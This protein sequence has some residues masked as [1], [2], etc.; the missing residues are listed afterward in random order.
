[1]IWEM[2]ARSC[3]LCLSF[4][5]VTVGIIGKWVECRRMK[6]ERRM[7]KIEIAVEYDARSFIVALNE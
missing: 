4:V 2:V 5:A 6:E 1:M 3:V 7:S